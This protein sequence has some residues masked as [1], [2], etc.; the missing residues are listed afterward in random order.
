MRV[1]LL[2]RIVAAAG[3]VV[4]SPLLVLV[5][6]VVRAS[7]PGPALYRARR[8][9]KGGEEFTLYK[10]R[11]MRSDAGVVGPRVTAA[12]DPRVTPV[13]RILRRTKLDELPQLVNVVRGEMAL[14][15]PRPEDPSFV[16]LDDPAY[17]ELYRYP[18]GITGPASLAYRD[19]EAILAELVADGRSVSDAY[20]ELARRK[21]E[22]DLEYLRCRTLRSDLGILA[23]TVGALLTRGGRG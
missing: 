2:D 22:I 3:L 1:R 12:G 18:P 21:L 6:I 13:G 14:V 5:G 4:L 11:S 17:A 16:D 23:R 8:L 20:L 7:S 15:G 19:E 10:F 9:G